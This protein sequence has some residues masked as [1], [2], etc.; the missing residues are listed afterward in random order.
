M[1]LK[2]KERESQSNGE[3]RFTL[4]MDSNLFETIS[5]IARKHKRS[6]AKEIECAIEHY[7]EHVLD[8]EKESPA[9]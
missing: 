3:K 6:I 4:R 9:D 8:E 5:L 1:S 7:V 2:V